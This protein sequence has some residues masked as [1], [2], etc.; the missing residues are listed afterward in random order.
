[1]NGRVGITRN[2]IS[3]L[4]EHMPGRKKPCLTVQKGNC[5]Y[6]V[7]SFNSEETADW[8]LEIV[9]EMIVNQDGK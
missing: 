7:A 5:I 1:M 9:D 8:F 6:K 3:I 2:N 4:V